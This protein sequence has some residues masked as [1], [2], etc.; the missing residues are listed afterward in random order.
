MIQMLTP[1]A[2]LAKALECE[3]IAAKLSASGGGDAMLEAAVMWQR[4][5]TGEM[6]PR[7]DSDAAGSVSTQEELAAVDERSSEILRQRADQY[8]KLATALD[9]ARAKNALV[10]LAAELELRAEALSDEVPEP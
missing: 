1:E 4:L 3:Q 9:D 10:E 6:T 5:E 8:S 2:C 7:K